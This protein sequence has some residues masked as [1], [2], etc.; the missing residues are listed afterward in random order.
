MLGEGLAYNNTVM[1]RR[2]GFTLVE[3]M[4]VIAIISIL[5]AIFLP[6]IKAVKGAAYAYNASSNVSQ[7]GTATTMY[8]AD[9]DDTAPPA[10]YWDGAWHGWYGRPLADGTNDP[11]QGLLA[12]YLKNRQL[13]DPIYKGKTYFGDGSGFGYNWGYVGGDFDATGNYQNF[14]FSTNPATMAQI[15]APSQ[16]IAFGTS[17]YFFAPWLAKGDG[18]NYNYGFI[19]APQ[20]WAGNPDV[21]FRHQ[22]NRLVDTANKRITSDGRALFVFLDSHTKSMVMSQVT[23]DMFQRSVAP[24]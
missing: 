21:D 22:G 3:L 15:E 5:M 23:D 11:S 10:L 24:K 14:P 4:M 16:T 2:R 12:S 17:N 20:F 19:S 9:S 1:R 13:K 18:N 7:L 6:V 8:A